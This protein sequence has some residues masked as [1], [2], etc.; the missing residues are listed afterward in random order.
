MLMNTLVGIDFFFV[1]LRFYEDSTSIHTC[2]TKI[3][4]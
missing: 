1:K 3:C 2:G 4:V